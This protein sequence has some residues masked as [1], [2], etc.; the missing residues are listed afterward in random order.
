MRYSERYA[1]EAGTIRAIEESGGAEALVRDVDLPRVVFAGRSIP[2]HVAQAYLNE[3]GGKWMRADGVHTFR[4]SPVKTPKPTAD[5]LAE[6]T[7]T[8]S[9]KTP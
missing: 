7:V 9:W 8:M 6:P 5:G 1:S 2:A 3:Y 4:A